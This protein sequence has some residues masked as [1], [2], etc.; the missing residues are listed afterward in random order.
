MIEQLQKDVQV[1]KKRENKGIKAQAIN[2][3]RK[4]WVRRARRQDRGRL[5]EY[6]ERFGPRRIGKTTNKQNQLE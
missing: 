5:E 6:V 2:P 1:M 3:R 4:Q